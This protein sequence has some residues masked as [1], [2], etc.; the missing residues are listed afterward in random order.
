MVGY[1]A[2][3]KY[4]AILSLSV[5]PVVLAGDMF[6]A[7]VDIAMSIKKK[8]KKKDSLCSPSVVAVFC[9]VS[10]AFFVTC[11]CYV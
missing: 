10:W 7:A 8:K 3:N 5:L 6:I 9:W 2:L 1:H 11:F 4:F